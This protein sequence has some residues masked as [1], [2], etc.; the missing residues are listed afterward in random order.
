ML[1]DQQAFRYLMLNKPAG[2]IC[3]RT[4]AT[5]RDT[6]TVYEHL[7]AAGFPT[8]LGHVGRLDVPT[9]GL[10]LFTD[11]GLLLQALT[12]HN[13]QTRDGKQP[14]WATAADA[15]AATPREIAKVYLCEI[16][17]RPPTEADLELM[18]QP[19]TYGKK[20]GQR[21]E[22]KRVTTLPAQVRAVSPPA[23]PAHAGPEGGGGGAAASDSTW[24][25]VRIVEGRNRQVRR[26][27]QRS[28]LSLRTLRRVSLGP[29]SLGS[30]P[31]AGV[32]WLT[33][34]EVEACCRASLP[35]RPLPQV[36]TARAEGPADAGDADVPAAEQDGHRSAK[37]ANLSTT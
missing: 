14:A 26:L 12:N 37:R 15:E 33:A 17:G 23:P 20:G 1:A 8:D 11:D 27:C 6:P 18:R 19:Y 2:C 28:R 13:P 31:L 32:R 36:V 10:L 3:A 16:G 30:L 5:G 24:V 29:L 4:V 34:A 22:E 7:A 21:P 35:G 25:E 9:E